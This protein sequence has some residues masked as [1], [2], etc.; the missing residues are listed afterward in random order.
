MRPGL[1]GFLVLL[2]AYTPAQGQNCPPPLDAAL[3]LVLVTAASMST[4]IATLRLFERN[5]VQESWRFLGVIEP[6]VVGRAGL[7]WGVDFWQYAHD[8][9]RRKVEGDRRTPTGI[10]P[11]T[12]TF[13]FSAS[14]RPGYLHI[15]EDTVCVD[16]PS[17]A[18]YNT[19]TSRSVVGGKVRGEDMR[20]IALY[21]RGIII[22]Y[23]T[24]RRERAGSCIFFHVWSGPGQGTRGCVALPDLKVASLQ[25]FVRSVAVAAILPEVA[26]SRFGTCLPTMSDVVPR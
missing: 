25:D 4:P 15:H 20:R 3:R 9:E 11:L 12:R 23:P 13:G 10:Y 2:L 1:S 6:A 7:G 24:D 8:G 18:A 26:L 21:R 14:Q 22:D 16:D 5:S 17:S 19:I